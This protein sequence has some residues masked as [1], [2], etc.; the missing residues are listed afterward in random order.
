MTLNNRSG[1]FLIG[2]EVEGSSNGIIYGIN[3]E[4]VWK[5][6]RNCNEDNHYLGH[7]VCIWELPNVKH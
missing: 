7:S 3:L 2:K 5:T 4:E 6:T 1:E